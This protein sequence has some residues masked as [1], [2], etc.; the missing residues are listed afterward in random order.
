[1]KGL[2]LADS[3]VFRSMDK[4][5]DT[6]KN[7]TSKVIEAK[8]KDLNTAEVTEKSIT[9]EEFQKLI[10]Y[11]EVL[12]KKIANEVLTGNIAINPTF[13][14]GENRATPCEMCAFQSIC[15]FDPKVKG[16]K[17]R[18]VSRLN[19]KAALDKM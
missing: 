4:N 15:A 5:I 11:A 7:N 9:N 6:N 3:N 1:M 8:L 2:I 14:V 17:Y 13:E 16:N 18:I 19:K 10:N 12:L